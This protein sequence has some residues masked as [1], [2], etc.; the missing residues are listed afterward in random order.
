MDNRNARTAHLSCSSVLRAS[1]VLGLLLSGAPLLSRAQDSVPAAAQTGG[2]PVDGSGQ[3][4][5]SFDLEHALLSSDRGLT[6]DDAGKRARERAPQIASAQA[7]S[8][9][10]SWDAK[11][12][13]SSFLPVVSLSAQYR[14]INKV[15]NNAFSMFLPPNINP[16]D[17]SFTQPVD[18]YS[19]AVTARWPVSDLFF[20]VWPAYK[21]S[22]QIAEARKLDVETR[23]ASAE[24]TAREA[25]YAHARAL[26]TLL[27]AE[28]AL[29][30]AEAQAAQAKLF[31]DAG[32]AAPVD[33]MTATAR[34][35]SMR[36]AMA[37]S[38]GSVAVSRNSLAVL[39]GIPVSEVNGIREPV[40]SLPQAPSKSVDELLALGL[41]QR[42]ELRALR[43]LV[44]A[45]EQ[46]KTAARAAALPVLSVEGTGLEANPNPRYV[47]PVA[48]FKPSYEVGATL[49]W[50]ANNAL[51][52]YQQTQRA[53]AELQRA[54]ADLLALEDGVRI[55]VV[56]SFEDY[57][58]ADAAAHASEAQQ[59]AAE[60]T[61]RVRLA[62]YRVGAGVQID[63]LTADY[64]LTQ[65]RLDRV[66]AAIDARI[67][68]ARLARATGQSGR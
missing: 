8:E 3:T 54:R 58:A 17:V 21:A 56:Q 66:N 57:K 47:P 20:R 64:A 37:R 55:E 39:M 44:G 2:L 5:V 12:Q 26:A 65:A 50:T 19:L 14:R 63:L 16:K 41:E 34:V 67:S 23:T 68:L 49:A 13:S 61:Y 28:Q 24:L 6:S 46:L 59:Q 33:L 29:K 48:K 42:P 53:S 25:F 31:V 51:T 43:K 22:K 35:E 32:T 7:T 45:N 4:D 15:E 9:S 18:N 36:S 62:T 27:V 40:T 30:Q 1:T 38:R 11:V 10:A 52:G 60:E